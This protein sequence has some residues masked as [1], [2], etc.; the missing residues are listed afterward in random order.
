MR[1]VGIDLSAKGEHKAVIV[2]EACRFVSPVFRFGTTPASLE[3]LLDMVQENNPDQQVQAVMEPT[4]M[5]WFPVAVFLIR[6][7]VRIY[8][9]N[10]QQVADLRKYFKKHAK[11]DRIDARVWPNCPLWMR[12]N[13]I[14]WNSPMPRHW[15]ASEVA[16]SWSG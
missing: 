5:A 16:S 9:V 14:V 15:P 10:S 8:L 12:R 2:D 3:R 7:G 1:T 6:N 13:Y 11:S 4:G